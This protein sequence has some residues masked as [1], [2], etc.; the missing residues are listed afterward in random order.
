MKVEESQA[1]NVFDKR[2]KNVGIELFLLFLFLL[3]SAIMLSLYADEE[4][5]LGPNGHTFSDAMAG[6][7]S[8]RFAL[9]VICFISQY[10]M[11]FLTYHRYVQRKRKGKTNY[12]FIHWGFASIFFQMCLVIWDT[13]FNQ[14]IHFAF[15]GF[16]FICLSLYIQGLYSLQT[17]LQP[18]II[19]PNCYL[20]LYYINV[21]GFFISFFPYYFLENNMVPSII[22]GIFEM[23]F[24]T[25]GIFIVTQFRFTEFADE[26]HEELKYF[27]LFGIHEFYRNTLNHHTFAELESGSIQFSTSY[28]SSGSKSPDKESADIGGTHLCV[29]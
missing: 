19:V 16:F 9:M 25:V 27:Q 1:V 18:K 17:L 10:E 20:W 15:A 14:F 24:M 29:N 21:V 12:R 23:T 11:N 6:A 22:S 3:V 4:V 28:I 2:L 7:I 8:K 13:K 5:W 26:H